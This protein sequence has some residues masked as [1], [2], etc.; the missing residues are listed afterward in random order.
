MR[1]DPVRE[2]RVR[3]ALLPTLAL[4][5]GCVSPAGPGMESHTARGA[6]VGTL[7]GAAL[8]AAIDGD[9]PGRGALIGAA[10]GGL[11]GGAWG[12]VLDAH[13]RELRD[14]PDV[15]VIRTEEVVV[16]SIPGDVLFEEDSASLSPGALAK[17][18]DVA[19]TLR[20]HPGTDIVVKGHSDDDGSSTYNQLLSE[21][22][23]EVVRD[24]LVREGV[25][26]ARITSIGYGDRLPVASNR[27]AAGRQQNRRVELEVRPA[28]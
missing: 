10:L 23:A 14:V 9:R 17:L 21:R 27:T 16:V 28:V 1:L 13:E 4:A 15:E 2:P 18:R 12:G 24:E 26:P 20:R 7:A 6:I 8:G 5:L 3:L 22:R 25:H 11:A 19:D